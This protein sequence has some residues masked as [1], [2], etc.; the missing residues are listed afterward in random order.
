[1]SER[2]HS[3]RLDFTSDVWKRLATEI[4]LPNSFP[5]DSVCTCSRPGGAQAKRH[6]T[7]DNQILTLVASRPFVT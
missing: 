2:P 7:V 6:E 5:K 1:M 3:H 4:R